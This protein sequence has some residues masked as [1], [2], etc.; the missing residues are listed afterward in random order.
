MQERKG[1]IVR[2]PRG[3]RIAPAD[4]ERLPELSNK[5]FAEQLDPPGSR[6]EV[7]RYSSHARFLARWSAP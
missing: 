6:R 1:K 7:I 2:G 5:G 4:L 3:I